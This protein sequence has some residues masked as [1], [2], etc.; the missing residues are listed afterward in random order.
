VAF[1]SIFLE[2]LFG[3]YLDAGRRRLTR[4]TVIENAAD[5]EIA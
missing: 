4:P 5:T 2:E 3:D 1:L